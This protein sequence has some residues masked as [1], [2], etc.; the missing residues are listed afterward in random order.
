M[1]GN[2]IILAYILD[3][4]QRS[5][6]YRISLYQENVTEKAAQLMESRK[7]RERQSAGGRE[8]KRGRE[9]RKEGGRQGGNKEKSQALWCTH[10]IPALSK[11]RWISAAHWPASLV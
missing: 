2:A 8:G 7:K 4:D 6:V 5:S 9:E 3:V 10:G 11:Y 1:V